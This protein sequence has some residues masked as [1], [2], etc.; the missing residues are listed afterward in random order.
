MRAALRKLGAALADVLGLRELFAFGGLTLACYGIW[1]IYPPAAWIGGGAA[2][3]WL[4]IKN[5][6]GR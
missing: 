5:T 4:G 2:L 3:F 1:Q 6:K